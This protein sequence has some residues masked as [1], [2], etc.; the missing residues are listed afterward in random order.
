MT[1]SSLSVGVIGAGEMVARY[2]LPTLHALKPS[3]RIDWLADSDYKKA[4]L[5]GNAYGVKPLRMHEQV[6][7]LP[8]T[9]VILVAIPYG[10]RGQYWKSLRERNS[11]VYLEKPI[12]QTAVEHREMCSWFA[13]HRLGC[14]YQRRSWGGTLLL[15]ELIETEL[16]GPLER[17][18]LGFGGPGTSQWSGYSANVDLAGGGVLF[19]FAVHWIDQMLFCTSAT[20]VKVRSGRMIVDEGYDLHTEALVS[21]MLKNRSVDCDMTISRL[22]DTSESMEFDFKQASVIVSYLTDDIVVRNKTG[23]RLYRLLPDRGPLHPKTPRQTLHSHW[24]EFLAG[25]RTATTNRTSATECTLTT[26]LLEA[27]YCAGLAE[28]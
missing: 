26:E 13:P 28:N 21:L 6:S 1:L 19:E 17:I 7:A 15:K 16:F 10:A 8:A 12:A 27:L 24:C 11:A 4:R 23:R 3:V 5:V 22:K 20:S 18:R 2:H 9:D 25:V 14:G